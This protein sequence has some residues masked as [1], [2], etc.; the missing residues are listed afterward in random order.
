MIKSTIYFSVLASVAFIGNSVLASEEPLPH[1]FSSG[2]PAK[3]EEVNENFTY[4]DERIKSLE[5]TEDSGWVS[6]FQ[7]PLTGTVSIF[8]NPFESNVV[9]GSNTLFLTELAVGDAIRIEDRVFQVKS[10]ESDTQLT[11]NDYFSAAVSD[12][13]A[14]ATDTMLSVKLNDRDKL[15]VNGGGYLIRQIQRVTG[16]DAQQ[17]LPYGGYGYVPNRKLDF[18]KADRFSMIRITY[19]DRVDTSVSDPCYYE[20]QVNKK[21]CLTPKPIR[22][23]KPSDEGQNFS[24]VLYCKGIDAGMNTIEVFAYKGCGIFGHYN[25]IDGKGV[26]SFWSLEAE[27]VY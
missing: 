17:F 12:V 3:A 13:P 14:Y 4:L 7:A 15:S 21:S 23:F 20:I 25:F 10:I 2:T 9:Y 1:V 24:D 18:Y 6:G 16:N 8:N 26:Y 11:L 19:T 5:A 22:I 27:E